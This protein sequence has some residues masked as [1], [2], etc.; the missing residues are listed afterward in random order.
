MTRVR[1]NADVDV[2]ID[3]SLE[4]ALEIWEAALT[5][6]LALRVRTPGGALIAINPNQVLYL[7][8]EEP[9]A[10]RNGQIVGKWEVA[11]AR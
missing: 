10:D 5:S 8:A 6:G 7:E 3:A 2:R 4:E 11:A 9:S 1:L